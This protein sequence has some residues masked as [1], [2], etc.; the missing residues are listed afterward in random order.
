MSWIK[1]IC[2]ALPNGEISLNCLPFLVAYMCMPTEFVLK[3][4][5]Y[6]LFVLIVVYLINAPWQW[7]RENI[8]FVATFITA[9]VLFFHV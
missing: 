8:I 3:F 1:K 6:F 2:R 5:T 7:H 9:K 4:V